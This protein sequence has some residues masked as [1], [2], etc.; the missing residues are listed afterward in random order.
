MALTHC[1]FLELHLPAAQLAAA[2]TALQ[3][4]SAQ[5]AWPLHTERLAYRAAEQMLFAYLRLDQAQEMGAVDMQGL[6]ATWSRLAP[7]LPAVLASRLEQGLSVAGHDSGSGRQPLH[8]YVVETD[9]APGW[10]AEIL[11]WY[12]QEHMPGLS[13]VPGCTLAQRFINHDAGPRSHAC[14]SLLTEDTLGSPPW[15]AVRNSDWSSRCR[16]HFTNTRR[17]MMAVWPE[18]AMQEAGG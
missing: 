6:Q 12:D 2:H 17:T 16:P 13:G 9:P 18:A 10:L 4:L 7:G 3:T 8:H 14:Y 11:R 15:M 5:S 1:I